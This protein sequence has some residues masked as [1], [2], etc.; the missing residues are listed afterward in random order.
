MIKN[1]QITFISSFNVKKKLQNKI[2]QK[3]LQLNSNGLPRKQQQQQ[4]EFTTNRFPLKTNIISYS[5]NDIKTCHERYGIQIYVTVLFKHKYNQMN[6]YVIH[7][8]AA[9]VFQSTS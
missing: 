6:W 3:R 8:M 7:A 4:R 1:T 9:L 5:W 2:R